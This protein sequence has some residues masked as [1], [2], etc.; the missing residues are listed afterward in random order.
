[1]ADIRKEELSGN[2]K[3]LSLTSVEVETLNAAKLSTTS[4]DRKR[5]QQRKRDTL[6]V[7]LSFLDIRQTIP[8]PAS[9]VVLIAKA[10]M[11][12]DQSNEC[13]LGKKVWDCAGV[14]TLDHRRRVLTKLRKHGSRFQIKDRKGRPS[15]IAFE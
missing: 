10:F 12:M 13:I 5:F 15:I 3:G 9:R 7:K 11:D 8:D 1:M 2:I 14:V 6:F 4:I